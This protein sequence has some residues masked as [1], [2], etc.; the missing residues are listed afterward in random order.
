MVARPRT[1]G[2]P[3]LARLLGDL[4]AER[5]FYIALARA[6]RGLVLDGGLA[7]GVR[8][9][10]ERDL[11]AALGV[12]RTTVTAAYDALRAESF[13]RSRQGAG[14]WTALPRGHGSV[15]PPAAA[16]TV[17]GAP[18]PEIDLGNAAPA[19]P[20]VFEEAVADAVDRLPGYIGGP[21]YDPAGIAPLREAIADRYGA[22]GLPTRPEQIVVTAGALQ[23][24]TLV[25]EELLTPGDSVLVE[26][27]TYPHALDALRRRGA[28]LIPVGVNAGWDIE[29]IATSMRQTAVRLGYVNPDFHNPTGHLMD[30]TR[31]AELAAATKRTGGYLISDETFAELS[32]DGRPMPPPL[33]A[34]DTDGRIIGIGSAAKL[35]WGGLRIGWIRTTPPLA[36]KI[37]TLRESVD[38]ASPVLEQ[39]IVRELLLR[40]EE[41]RAERKALLGAGRDAALAAL[42]D[43]LP[44]WEVVV[45]AGGMSLW[46][47]LPGPVSSALAGA[48]ARLGVRVVPGP[49]F[50]VD[51]L[52]EDYVR[53]PFVQPPEVLRDAVERLAQAYHSV[54]NAAAPRSVLS[55]V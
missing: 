29:L 6:I 24:L 44:E 3:Q 55:Y 45:P 25:L 13:V 54:E 33:G 43:L 15:R 26:S 18:E 35:F 51:G 28:R 23:A 34:Y 41:V 12:S 22:R 48:A 2:G 9:P 30:D 50:G 4:P 39:L 47:R 38:L 7:L 14:S 16:R 1:I 49:L 17:L 5:P 52:L 40:V 36:R 37:A 53:L 20:E 32:L 27:P 11:A 10:A 21:G 31:R 46:V 8:L 19:A 42:G